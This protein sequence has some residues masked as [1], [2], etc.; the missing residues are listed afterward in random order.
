MKYLSPCNHCQCDKLTEF[1]YEA[2]QFNTPDR[3]I[4]S[5]FRIACACGVSGPWMLNI[6]DAVRAWDNMDSRNRRA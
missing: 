2:R 4:E 3:R 6:E 5:R 1:D